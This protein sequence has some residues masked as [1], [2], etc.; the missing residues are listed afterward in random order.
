MK[1]L[2]LLL[3]VSFVLITPGSVLALD[4]MD[5]D[6][7]FNQSSGTRGAS[8]IQADVEKVTEG[9]EASDNKKEE[10]GLFSD[11]QEENNKTKE[12]EK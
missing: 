6:A 11:G 4:N 9:V 10:S 12:S 2:A 3:L 5:D 7:E 1:K 8:G